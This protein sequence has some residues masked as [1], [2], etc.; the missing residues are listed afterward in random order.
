MDKKIKDNSNN[1]E[2]IFSV[3]IIKE[4]ELSYIDYS[5][6]VIV[7][8]AL[9]DVRDGLKPVHRRVLYG[10][11]ELNLHYNKSYKK[12]ARI[13]GEVLGKYHPHGDTSVYD[14]MVRMAQNWVLRYPLVN[15]QGNFGSIDGDNP[16]AMR[17]TEV[18]FSKI[19]EEVLY[20]IND[21]TVDYKD[22]FDGSL[23][24]P[25]ILPTMLPN[26]ILNGSS[27][28][29]VGLATNMAPHNIVES[30]NAIIAFIDNE[31]I[32]IDEI[33]KHI[34]AP[35][36]PTGGIIHGLEGV[37]SSYKTGKGKIILKSRV[38]IVEYKKNFHR[39][40]VTEIPYM[41]S[42]SEMIIKTADLVNKKSIDGI[43]S[44]RDESDRNGIKIVYDIKYGHD[45]NI[46]LNS[47]YKNTNL[48]IA[49]NVNN[50]ALVDGNPKLLNIKDMIYCFYKHIDNVLI[51][52]TK[53][54]LKNN[55]HKLHLLEGYII[56]SNNID[57][58]ISLIKKSDN[59]NDANNILSKTFNLSEI[60]SK[61]ILDIKLNK[62]TKLEKHKIT[63]NYK[64][65]KIEISNCKN[66][67]S[68]EIYRKNILKSHLNIIKDKYGDKRRTSILIDNKQKKSLEDLIPNKNFIITIS[69]VGYIKRTD[70]TEYK[71]QSRGGI[72]IIGSKLR[73]G[74]NIEHI[75]SANTHDW[76][77]L[78]TRKGKC[79]WL[80]AYSI[81]ESN[82][83]SK[84][85]AIQN[86]LKIDK[87][88][89]I[90]SFIS[91]NSF[92]EKFIL[93]KYIIM[94]TKNGLIKKTSLKYYSKPRVNGINA[95]T[96]KENDALLKAELVSYNSEVFMAS[97]LGYSVRFLE[98][99][100]RPMNRSAVGVFGMRF[101]KK[102]DEIVNMVIINNHESNIL[103][104]SKNG[105]GKRTKITDYRITNRGAKG[106]KVMNINEKTG[107]LVS[108]INV[109]NED[110]MIIINK[111]GITI[112][113]AVNKIRII[114]R[115]TQ[116]VKL[117]R[118]KNNDQIASIA[119]I[120]S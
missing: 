100:V 119:I 118:L 89:H 41:V 28:I 73:D 22:N 94:C 90:K 76:I 79:F 18:K 61:S 66:I 114:G 12:S 115:A 81:P 17:Y 34:K 54:D 37:I 74:D 26:L 77:L 1:K 31:Q 104:I 3:D 50:I 8:R 102:D 69:K 59:I 46:V 42:K 57:K 33:I 32:S 13:V 52:K 55:E 93:N 96:I 116:G 95:I 68:D 106:I 47:L 40:I 112:R 39:I 15:G 58:A 88:D 30:I 27:G 35:D 111:S 82:K 53:Y 105:Y 109:N 87:S 14:S 4:M 45:P 48:E 72:G 20:H 51:R 97:K 23:K 83:K 103:A 29:A 64:N 91:V 11:Y 62:L 120:L 6:S 21:D 113:M 56:I 107:N 49:F 71:R 25:K 63:E 84:G 67:I 36:F 80:K 70:S 24:E 16:A 2:N 19:C 78:F 60:Q 86:L 9:P 65:T 5:M 101:S 10:M 38:K 75:I 43:S 44:I 85:R 99:S 117:I 92:E 7:S 108:V 98:S 110:D